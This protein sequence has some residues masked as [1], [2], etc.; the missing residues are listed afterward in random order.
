MVKSKPHKFY[1]SKHGWYDGK[2]YMLTLGN[3]VC[4]RVVCF[5]RRGDDFYFNYGWIE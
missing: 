4:P 2:I 3:L 1:H 5:A